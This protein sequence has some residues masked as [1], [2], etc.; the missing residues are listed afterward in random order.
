MKCPSPPPY[1]SRRLANRKA[2]PLMMAS[3]WDV[4]GILGGGNHLEEV[5]HF[6]LSCHLAGVHQAAVLGPRN[7]RLDSESMS[8]NESSLPEIVERYVSGTKQEAIHG[9]QT[10][11]FCRSRH[12]STAMESMFWNRLKNLSVAIRG[13]SRRKG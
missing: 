4:L 5:G 10:I 9:F 2:V 13:S 1:P 3:W 11:T 8:Q 12:K 7:C 6:S